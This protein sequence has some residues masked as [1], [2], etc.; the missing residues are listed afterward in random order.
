MKEQ[1]LSGI[2]FPILNRFRHIL[3]G[4]GRPKLASDERKQKITIT[5]DPAV[6]AFIDERVGLGKPFKNRTHGFEFAV[7]QL[8]KQEEALHGSEKTTDGA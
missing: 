1:F 4:V 8:M 5:P 2:Y 6:V 3:P 7:A